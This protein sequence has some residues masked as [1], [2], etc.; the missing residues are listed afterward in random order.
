MFFKDVGG[1]RLDMLV[2]LTECGQE[3]VADKFEELQDA[4]KKL[5]PREKV[6]LEPAGASDDGHKS[7]SSRPSAKL[8]SIVSQVLKFRGLPPVSKGSIAHNVTELG[9]GEYQSTLT[10]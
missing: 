1:I 7:K 6:P 4:G 8:M 2:Q 5:E 9:D 10:L 3:L